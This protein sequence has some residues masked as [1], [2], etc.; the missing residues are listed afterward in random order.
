MKSNCGAKIR[1]PVLLA[2]EAFGDAAKLLFGKELDGYGA[3]TLGIA[4]HCDFCSQDSL[5]I[6][7]QMLIDDIPNGRNFAF[8]FACDPSAD[9]VFGLTDIPWSA[10]SPF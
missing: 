4:S 6:F 7:L 1:L 9:G 8:C 5:K 2:D 10:R 3:A